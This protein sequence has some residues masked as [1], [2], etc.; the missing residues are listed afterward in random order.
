MAIKE[1]NTVSQRASRRGGYLETGA[2]STLRFSWRDDQSSPY[3]RS[4]LG[5]VL[6]FT[7]KKFGISGLHLN[8]CFSCLFF[9]F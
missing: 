4:V 9:D 7:V 8:L 5:L 3:P 6:R 1:K 2:Q